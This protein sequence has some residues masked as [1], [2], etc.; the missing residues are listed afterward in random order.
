MG[1]FKFYQG[2]LTEIFKQIFETS[3]GKRQGQILSV[4]LDF[5][6]LPF[7]VS[8]DNWTNKDLASMII[9]LEDNDCQEVKHRLLE[10]R[11]IYDQLIFNPKEMYTFLLIETPVM[12]DLIVFTN[13]NAE[14]FAEAVE[15]SLDRAKQI[16]KAEVN[17]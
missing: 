6:N 7:A 11:K 13:L 5:N 16:I 4:N 8:I 2:N 9:N 10:M 15:E 1:H 3:E 17:Q 14:D 12:D